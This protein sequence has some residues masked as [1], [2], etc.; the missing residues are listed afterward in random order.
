MRKGGRAVLPCP[1]NMHK[2]T[3]CSPDAPGQRAVLTSLLKGDEEIAGVGRVSYF[4]FP[5][6]Y[7]DCPLVRAFNAHMV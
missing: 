2:I 1:R 5:G 7:Q 4:L 3:L 6:G